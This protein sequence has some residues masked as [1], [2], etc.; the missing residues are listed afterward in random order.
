MVEVRIRGGDPRPVSRG[1]FTTK[2]MG[3]VTSLDLQPQI[4]ED[5][6]K[7]TLDYKHSPRESDERVIHCSKK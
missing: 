6:G 7:H 5:Q 2:H 3:E 1:N 4:S